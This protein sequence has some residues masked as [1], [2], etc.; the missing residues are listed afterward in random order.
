MSIIFVSCFTNTWLLKDNWNAVLDLVTSLSTFKNV[1]W[2]HQIAKHVSLLIIKNQTSTVVKTGNLTGNLEEENFTY[3]FIQYDHLK[4]C[5]SLLSLEWSVLIFCLLLVSV[6]IK[7][8]SHSFG[9]DTEAKIRLVLVLVLKCL[10]H[11]YI[12]QRTDKLDESLI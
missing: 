1:C 9:F 10:D 6:T 5:K 3:V 4:N 2:S 7:I 8:L 12:G 11:Y